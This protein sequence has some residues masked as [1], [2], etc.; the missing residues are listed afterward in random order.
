MVTDNPTDPPVQ[1]APEQPKEGAPSL[2]SKARLPFNHCNLPAAIL[3]S[4]TFQ[5]HPTALA[6][7][8]VAELHHYLF[9]QLNRLTTSEERAAHF[10]DYMTVYF[11]LEALEEIGLTADIA[12]GRP[13]AHYLQLLRGWMFDSDS[14]EGAVMKG[15]VES[16]FG[17][18]PRFHKQEI[19][20]PE[21]SSYDRFM[22]ERTLGLYNTNALEA[23]L[24]LLYAYCQYELQRRHE[25]ATHVILYRGVHSLPEHDWLLHT[26]KG[27]GVVLLNNLNSFSANPERAD[28]FGELVLQTRVPLSKILFFSGLLPGWLVGEDEYIVIGG[29]YKVSPAR[30]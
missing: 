3:G 2:P 27:K 13:K 28:E 15:W 7:D 16:R 14:R 6:I 29:L 20:D 11:R 25:Q 5:L 23:Q 4:L 17:L 18:I 24:D 22:H 12:K 21:D 26:G 9:E 10:C 1:R 19:R 30:Y 8:G